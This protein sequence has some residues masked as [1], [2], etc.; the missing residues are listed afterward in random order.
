MRTLVR[1]LLLALLLVASVSL[2]PVS[3]VQG[4][5]VRE[6]PRSY[7]E[8]QPMAYDNGYRLGRQ[9]GE[10]DARAGRE[11]N[12]TEDR[13][14]QAADA[15]Y[16]RDVDRYID[17]ERYRRVFRDGYVAGYE[18]GFTRERGDDRVGQWSGYS[19]DRYTPEANRSGVLR[20][21]SAFEPT[22]RPL[23]RRNMPF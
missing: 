6:Y 23:R 10:S 14:Y 17:I 22:R 9:H 13:E 16:Q 19:G 15:G 1:P 2:L 18:E 3:S 8:W 11:F 5:Y 20:Q 12:Y 7:A 4:Q 21:K